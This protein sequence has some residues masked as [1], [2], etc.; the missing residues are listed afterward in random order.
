MIKKPP[1][2]YS[3][4]IIWLI[5]ILY[6][7]RFFCCYTGYLK[8]YSWNSNSDEPHIYLLGLKFFLTHQFPLWG[9]DNVHPNTHSFFVGGLQGL[10]VGLPL[11]VWHHPF[12]PYVFL[13]LINT[14]C[15]LYLSVYITKLL[16][17][18]KPWLIYALIALSPFSIWTGLHIINP[19]YVMCFAVPFMLA[20]ME[21]MDI[22]EKKFIGPLWRYFWLGLGV[23]SVFQLHGSFILFAIL[24]GIAIV[25]TCMRAK[26]IKILMLQALF[27]F[28]GLMA[29]GLSL[30]P[31]IYHYGWAVIAQQGSVVAFDVMNAADLGKVIFY[32]VTVCGY[33]MNA[34]DRAYKWEGFMA[35]GN[36]VAALVF[37]ILQIA[38]LLLFGLQIVSLLFK[39]WRPF[40][41]ADKKFLLFLAGLV[42]IVT[43]MFLF[44]VVRPR[45]YML[46]ALYPFSALYLFWF[47]QNVLKT[48]VIKNIWF[49]AFAALLLL[50]YAEVG[51]E[52]NTLPDLGYRA[53]AFKALE[54]K[55]PDI[56]ETARFDHHAPLR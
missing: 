50:Y 40:V 8:S 34:I 31:V 26:G 18:C 33:E 2:S 13:F 28:L 25:Y 48:F 9:P 53:K 4:T 15:L 56:F 24:F 54:N 36:I 1:Y 51:H 41:T 45:G 16:P 12:A 6:I 43:S 23:T 21:T 3:R 39:K 19:A 20:F 35:N 22:F 37:G 11:F 14:A 44:S 10:M 42:L 55:D 7:F 49:G 30:I 47:L 32:L 17:D 38:G 5:V 46:L 52:T 27:A 29:G